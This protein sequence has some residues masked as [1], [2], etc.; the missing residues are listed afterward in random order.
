MIK[1]YFPL[2]SRS[3]IAP[4][5]ASYINANLCQLNE[6]T[7]KMLRRS[8]AIGC[9]SVLRGLNDD[10]CV[11]SVLSE[12]EFVWGVS[13]DVPCTHAVFCLPRNMV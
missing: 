11:I 3:T 13:T 1:M 5:A 4:V 7:T 6:H 10:T 9:G 12:V 2:G 8:S